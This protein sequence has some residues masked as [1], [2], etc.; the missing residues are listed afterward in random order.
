M[1]AF[2]DEELNKLLQQRIGETVVHKP[3]DFAKHLKA[4]SLS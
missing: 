1:D 2:I 4:S 3:L